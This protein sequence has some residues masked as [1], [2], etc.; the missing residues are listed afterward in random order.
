MYKKKKILW[1]D[2]SVKST[3]DRCAEKILVGIMEQIDPT[4]NHFMRLKFIES[5]GSKNNSKI[6][7]GDDYQ[8]IIEDVYD[9]SIFPR[10]N[11]EVLLN[12]DQTELV[13]VKNVCMKATTYIWNATVR[14]TEDGNE[15]FK[16]RKTLEDEYIYTCDIYNDTITHSINKFKEILHKNIGDDK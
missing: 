2:E 12:V 4:L 16:M 1:N 9:P 8:V 14:I 3:V 11:L 15:V 7:P 5:L 10:I 6:I 13:H